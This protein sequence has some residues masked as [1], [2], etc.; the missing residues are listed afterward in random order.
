MEV[1]GKT[2]TSLGPKEHTGQ[3]MSTTL[4]IFF[5]DSSEKCVGIVILK[6]VTCT[7]SGTEESGQQAS[8]P[9]PCTID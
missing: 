2:N 8:T 7:D 3:S 6:P 1:Y 9:H 5:A 4:L